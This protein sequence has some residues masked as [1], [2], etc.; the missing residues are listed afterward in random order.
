MSIQV[1]QNHYFALKQKSFKNLDLIP[2]ELNF[3]KKIDV[4]NKQDLINWLN[5]NNND[6]Y[7][8]YQLLTDSMVK[9]RIKRRCLLYRQFTI[10]KYFVLDKFK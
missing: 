1:K 8:T 2:Y 10:K 3:N 5:Y 9:N 4:F 7:F 6:L